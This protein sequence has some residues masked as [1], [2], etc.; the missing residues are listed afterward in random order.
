MIHFCFDHVIDPAQQIIWPNLVRAPADPTVDVLC[1][2]RGGM[3]G[4]APFVDYPRILD[5]LRDEQVTHQVHDVASAPVGSIYL[6]NICWFDHYQDYLSMMSTVA[7][8]RLKKREIKFVIMYGEADSHLNIQKT[9]F[10]LCNKHNVNPID[11]HVILGNTAAYIT[12]NFHY[13]DD[14][15]II[16]QRSQQYSHAEKI[17]WCPEPKNR[18]MTLLSRVHKSWRAYF[19]SWYWSQGYHHNSYFSYR[20]IDQGE[21]LSDEHNPLNANIKFNPERKKILEDFLSHTPFS[22]DQ[23]TDAEHNFYGCRVDQHYQ[24]SYWNCVLETHISLEDDLP[25]V[26]IT[27]KTWKAIAHA[28]PFVILGTPNSLKHLKSLGYETFGSVGIDESYDSILDSSA[29]F[30]AVCEVVK[31]IHSLPEQKLHYHHLA[32]EE[33]VKHNQQLYWQNKQ[34]QLERL[35]QEIVNSNT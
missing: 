26:F 15:E 27:E 5:Y 24:D 35:F 9:I 21:D 28:Q 29:R 3:S 6:V 14:D 31:K 1:Q 18:R 30:H 32:L 25:G 17:V 11:I 8:E 22:A 20:M 2:Q 7:L 12:A 33:I 4:Q 16:F 19:C 23:L 34:Q 10:K 13:F